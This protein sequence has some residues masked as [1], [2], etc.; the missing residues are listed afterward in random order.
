VDRL[1][2]RLADAERALT[3]LHE[4]TVRAP[5]SGV[6]RDAAIM[7]FAYTFEAVWKAAQH[8]LD[9]SEGLDVGS[10]KQCVRTSRRVGLLTDE[11]AEAALQ[12]ADDRNLI[13]HVYREA[14]A[15]DIDSRLAAHATTLAAWLSA[16]R[17]RLG[18]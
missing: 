2:E 11:Q 9:V 16:I 18:A 14:V 3:S 4:L 13:V 7:R 12:M 6:E 8:F 15:R 5:R 17:Q 1:S 10:P